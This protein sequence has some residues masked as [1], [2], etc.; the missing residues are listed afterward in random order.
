MTSSVI[1]SDQALLFAVENV[2]LCKERKP[3]VD[4]F[5]DF[6]LDRIKQITPVISDTNFLY[7]VEVEGVHNFLI[8]DALLSSNWDGDE[9]GLM[10]LMDALLNFSH[11][12]IPDKRGGKMDL[13]LILTTRL[14]PSEVDK[15]AHNL[16]TLGRYPLEFYEATLKHEHSK[17]LGS[18]R[19]DWSQHDSAQNYSTSSFASRMTPTISRKDHENRST[20]P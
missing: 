11:A 5:G 9:D 13:P 14:D 19:W 2:A 12:Y 1:P 18:Q 6:I 10:L 16:D 4:M 3:R 8:N 20:R 15:E 17:N 7:D